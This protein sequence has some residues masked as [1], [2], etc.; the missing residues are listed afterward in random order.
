MLPSIAVTGRP[1]FETLLTH[2]FMVDKDG[3]K[4][5]KSSGN[6]LQVEALLKDFGADVCRWWVSSLAFESDIKVDLEFFELA[7]ESY[8]KVR[9]TLRFLLG[10][11]DGFVPSEGPDPEGLDAASLDAWVLEKT[12]ELSTRV[13]AAYEKY[14]F[15][16][17]HLALFDFCNDTLSAVYLDA[18]KDRLYCDL[19]ESPRRRGTQAAMWRIAETLATLLAPILPHTADEA[20][21]ALHGS[22]ACVQLGHFSAPEGSAHKDWSRVME[23]RDD[24]KKALEMAKVRGIE[25][26]IDA[27]VEVPDPDGLL[28]RFAAEL[29]DLFGV[30]RVR[31]AAEADAVSVL[32]LKDEPR[33]ERSWRRDVS[34]KQRSDGGWLSDRDAEAVGID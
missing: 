33:C 1:A 34:V 28:A 3:R 9:N 15:R 27:A 6:A 8:R 22:E 21:R 19:P 2:G 10:N 25:N 13:R 5:S 7:G 18:V 31:C 32:D 24:V 11:L 26:P 29:P 12:A 30:S 4:M 23:V 14:E 17:A 20:W 16:T